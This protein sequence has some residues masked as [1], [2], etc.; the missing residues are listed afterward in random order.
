MSFDDFCMA[1]N[2]LYICRWY[3]PKTWKY[4]DMKGSWK[5]RHATQPVKLDPDLLSL[6]KYREGHGG[7]LEGDP[8]CHTTREAGP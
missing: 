7:L 5:V 6:W 4:R 2:S 1:F 8:S 3:N